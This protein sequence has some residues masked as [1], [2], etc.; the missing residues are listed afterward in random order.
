MLSS[1]VQG[2]SWIW[3]CRAKPGKEPYQLVGC[4][5]CTFNVRNHVMCVLRELMSLLPQLDICCTNTSA[6]DV[7]RIFEVVSRGG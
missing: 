1:V 3:C 6:S 5:T 4:C 2:E 7:P